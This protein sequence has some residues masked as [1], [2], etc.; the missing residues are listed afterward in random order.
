MKGLCLRRQIQK[1]Q[2]TK[3]MTKNKRQLKFEKKQAVFIDYEKAFDS[4]KKKIL[5]G[6]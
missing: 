3:Q 2:P 1:E 4:V 5:V 6:F